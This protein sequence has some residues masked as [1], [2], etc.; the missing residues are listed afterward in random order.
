MESVVV[1]ELLGGPAAIQRDE[2]GSVVQEHRG[3]DSFCVGAMVATARRL[4]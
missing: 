4:S 3:S 2:R 1:F